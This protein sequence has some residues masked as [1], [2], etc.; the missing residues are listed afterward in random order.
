MN[1]V[2]EPLGKSS[3]TELLNENESAIMSATVR[4]HSISRPPTNGST[5]V[6]A[7]I[8]T[9]GCGRKVFGSCRRRDGTAMRR[10]KPMMVDERG[11]AGRGA[12]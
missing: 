4:M 6:S 9:G 1:D 11:T 2:A 8:A 5:C 3:L 7:R 10:V 12:C